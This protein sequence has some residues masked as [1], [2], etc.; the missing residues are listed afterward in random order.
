MNTSRNVLESLSILQECVVVIVNSK[1]PCTITESQLKE[2]KE[3]LNPCPA[4]LFASIFHSFEAGIADTVRYYKYI[5]LIYSFISFFFG[6]NMFY[7][8]EDGLAMHYNLDSDWH[9]VCN[10]VLVLLL[11]NTSVIYMTS[12][13]AQLTLCCPIL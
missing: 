11:M 5:L 9:L 2:M 13:T 3:N 4:E 7:F 1:C 8:L 10:S 12:V 6:K